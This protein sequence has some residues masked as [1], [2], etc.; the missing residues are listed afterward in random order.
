MPRDIAVSCPNCEALLLGFEP[1]PDPRAHEPR[2]AD[3]VHAGPVYGGQLRSAY[4]VDDEGRALLP[5]R[6]WDGKVLVL[7]CHMP[8]VD[9]VTGERLPWLIAQP[10]LDSKDLAYITGLSRSAYNAA[11]SGFPGRVAGT[12]RV[13]VETTTFLREYVFGTLVRQSRWRRTTRAQ[14]KARHR[15][16]CRRGCRKQHRASREET[17]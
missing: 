5:F 3:A 4:R 8:A 2:R 13:I 9:P 12:R 17:P 6:R 11:S 14:K 1:C 16:D 7:A 10:F 15:I